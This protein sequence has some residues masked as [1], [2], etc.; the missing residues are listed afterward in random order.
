VISQD[1]K[2]F[3][4]RMAAT[5][6]SYLAT[7]DRA[8]RDRLIESYLFVV[9]D[10]ARRAHARLGGH[11]T[12]DD[13]ESAGMLGLMDAV[14]AFDPSRGIAFETFAVHRVRGAMLDEVRALDWV[15]RS[16]R[17]A[18]RRLLAGRAALAQAL[19]RVAT[20]DE[21]AE[22]LRLPLEAVLK[23]DRE[24]RATQVVSLS[25]L[26]AA[27]GDDDSHRNDEPLGANAAPDP[28]AGELRD[29]VCGAFL[30][31]LSRTERLIVS[32]YYV[33]GLTFREVGRSLGLS[34][35]RV[36]QI[37]AR[38]LVRLRELAGAGRAKPASRTRAA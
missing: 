20:H 37:H 24:T 17:V 29:E 36:S 11:V 14:D 34:E 30:R 19:G 4:A 9:R 7:R 18:E 22:H 38:A 26:T 12:L 28:A 1:T 33:E 32:L 2:A 5:W 27:R 25:A 6:S 15:P 21:V 16:V 31:R 23:M 8:A 35:G 3:R 13:L 10:A